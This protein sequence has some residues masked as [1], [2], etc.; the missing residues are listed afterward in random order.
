MRFAQLPHSKT[1][2]SVGINFACSSPVMGFLQLW[3]PTRSKILC[4]E[5]QCFSPMALKYHINIPF[6]R[7][8][9]RGAQ[10]SLRSFYTSYS[11]HS[12]KK[13]LPTFKNDHSQRL[14]CKAAKHTYLSQL[15][16]QHW[17][18]FLPLALPSTPTWLPTQSSSMN[19]PQSQHQ[20]RGPRCNPSPSHWRGNW[21]KKK[22]YQL[23][24]LQILYPLRDIQATTEEFVEL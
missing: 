7:E 16:T 17:P 12:S 15:C 10:I 22:K 21:Q 1:F 8:V 5:F 9:K 13:C 18:S 24:T 20:E 23:T 6:N 2:Q 14:P 19:A 11:R 4:L 3:F